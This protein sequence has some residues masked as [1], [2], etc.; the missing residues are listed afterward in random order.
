VAEAAGPWIVDAAAGDSVQ[1]GF[2]AQKF[3]LDD[4]GTGR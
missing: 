2:R 4:A 3:T 1:A